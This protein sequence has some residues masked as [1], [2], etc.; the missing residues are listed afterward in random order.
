MNTTMKENNL[1]AAAAHINVA[2]AEV[3]RAAIEDAGDVIWAQ[4]DAYEKL[5]DST[6][7]W[8][9]YMESKGDRCL[10]LIETRRKLTNKKNV[11]ITIFM[12]LSELKWQ[13]QEEKEN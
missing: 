2:L 5:L 8:A 3:R 1:K 4:V 6:E 9:I 12:K 13:K 7:A 10:K 11:L